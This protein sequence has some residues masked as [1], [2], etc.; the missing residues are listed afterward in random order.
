MGG[1][2]L[3]KGDLPKGLPGLRGLAKPLPSSCRNG[4]RWRRSALTDKPP[5][6]QQSLQESEDNV[7]LSHALSQIHVNVPWSWIFRRA[8]AARSLTAKGLGTL[9]EQLEFGSILREMNLLAALPGEQATGPRPRPPWL[10]P[11]RAQPMWANWT[12]RP[13]PAKENSLPSFAELQQ[14][15]EITWPATWRCAWRRAWTTTTA[16]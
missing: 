8:I 5:K 11:D 10:H 6:V 3:N 1:L 2:P 16:G 7:K 4:I 9:L 12:G 14:F 13:P 15:P